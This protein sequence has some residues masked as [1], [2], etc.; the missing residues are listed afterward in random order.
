MGS[1]TEPDPYTLPKLPLFSIPPHLTEPSGTLT[2]P[3]QTTTASV[4]FQWEEQPGKPR[5]CTDIIISTTHINKCLELP[6]RLAKTSSPTTVLEG[7]SVFSSSSFRFAKERRRRGQLQGSFDSNCSG[8]W[9][10]SPNEDKDGGQVDDKND[11]NVGRGN[12]QFGSFRLLSGGR[13]H[14]GSVVISSLASMD[15]GFSDENKMRRNSSL[16][17][18]TRSH[19]WA[20]VYKGF[21]QVVPWRKKTTKESFIL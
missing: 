19:F 14:K 4:P 17:K 15:A 21:K 9:S 2:P 1:N 6:P 12:R 20:T 11:H 5:P 10:S 18:V 7:K 16:S 13:K 8:G 3:L